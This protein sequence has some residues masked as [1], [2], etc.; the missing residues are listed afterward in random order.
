MLLAGNTPTTG[1]DIILCPYKDTGI[2]VP[3]QDVRYGATSTFLQTIRFALDSAATEL[4]T[5]ICKAAGTEI[6]VHKWVWLAAAPL[7]LYF[8]ITQQT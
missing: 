8:R 5:L 6:W 1:S 2:L 4:F 7:L 3:S